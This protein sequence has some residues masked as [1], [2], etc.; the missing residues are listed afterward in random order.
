MFSISALS[1]QKQIFFHQT[2]SLCKQALFKPSHQP[3]TPL[4]LHTQ[5]D[6]PSWIQP[7]GPLTLR[8]RQGKASRWYFLGQERPLH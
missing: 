7:G 3:R 4:S 6:S 8:V 1:H 5:E 2:S